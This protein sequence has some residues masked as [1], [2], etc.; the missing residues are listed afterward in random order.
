MTEYFRLHGRAALARR[1]RGPQRNGPVS[2]T[3]V[4]PAAWTV[5][6]GLAGGDRSRLRVISVT[7]VVVENRSRRRRP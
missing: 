3:R 2:V 1:G 7:V 5:A 4:S 6:L